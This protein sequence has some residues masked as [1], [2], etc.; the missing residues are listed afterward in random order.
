MLGVFFRS[1]VTDLKDFNKIEAVCL[2]LFGVLMIVFSVIDFNYVF[3]ITEVNNLLI[4]ENNKEAGIV[5][6]KRCFMVISGIA[7]FTGAMSVVLTSKKKLSNYFWGIINTIAYGLFAWAYGYIGD[8]QL[9][10]CFF[11]PFQFIGIWLWSKHM[12]ADDNAIPRRL[13]V[14]QWTLSLLL[15]LGL[16][17]AFYY[18]IPE[19]AKLIEGSYIFENDEVPRRLDATT[20]ALS[21]VAQIL[22]IMRF[23][24]QWIFWIAIDVIQIA[25]YV[26]VAGFG[27]SFNITAMWILF[28]LNAFYGFYI[29]F[30]K[31][32]PEDELQKKDNSIVLTEIVNINN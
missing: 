6:W 11:L 12:D 5:L 29:W 23:R 17:F 7:S 22:M 3:N 28:L 21:V 32:K 4:W 16:G 27:I 2:F 24:E 14:L 9:N 26:G 13:N 10:L 1:I 15:S 30:I 25:M 31:S 19:V 20:N 18:E 8:S